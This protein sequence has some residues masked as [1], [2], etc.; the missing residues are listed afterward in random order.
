MS[1]AKLAGTTAKCALVLAGLAFSTSARAECDRAML[2]Q[3]TDTYV[4][5]QATGN[6][7]LLQFATDAYYGEN[8]LPVAS[9]GGI[10]TQ[11]LPIDFTRS[12]HD[13]AHCATFTE[14]TAATHPHPYVIHTRMEVTEAG[15]VSV[16]ESVVTDADD[17]VFGADVHL[18]QTRIENW[19]EIPADQ[20]DRRG[21]LQAAAE[22]YINNWGNPD[23]PVPHGTPCSR[24]E[25]RIFTGA[26]DPEG[27]TC[28]MGAFPQPIQT[29]SRRYVID[30]ALGAVSIFHNFSWIDAGL[31][32]Y[33]P[34]TPASQTFRIENGMNRYIH[35][36][37]ACIT[38]NC[39]R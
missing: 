37:T 36:V 27:Q 33:H 2:Q 9:A 32:P 7:G 13:T 10:L 4:E 23:L 8:D 34:G 5:A 12:F 21:V 30:E 20:R 24:L 28:T 18:A 6:P 38:P 14:I 29:G 16:M 31:G 25:G 1:K 22:A 17:W 19:G 15:E 3:L 11:A 35:E 26:R 39:G